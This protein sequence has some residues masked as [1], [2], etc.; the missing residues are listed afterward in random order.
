MSASSVPTSSTS[1]R[2][3][4]WASTPLDCAAAVL[5]KLEDYTKYRNFKRFH[6]GQAIGFKRMLSEQIS[7]SV[8]VER[9]SAGV[10]EG[11][12]DINEAKTS[13]RDARRK[14]FDFLGYSFG[15]HHPHN[16]GV[17]R[18]MSASARRE[19][20]QRLKT[21]VREQSNSIHLE[22]IGP[23]RSVRASFTNHLHL[24]FVEKRASSRGSNFELA[25]FVD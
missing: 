6:I 19:S 9:P 16:S 21:K 12:V 23:K 3:G 5:A 11:G 18:C 22:A 17:R 2:L 1:R 8:A 15:P 7:V 25:R 24:A 4:V 13:L 14:R 20:V 10:D